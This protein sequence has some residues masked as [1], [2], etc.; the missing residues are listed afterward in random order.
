MSEP[1]YGLVYP[2][3]VCQSQGGPYDDGAFVAGC[4][5]GVVREKCERGDPVIEG[6]EPVALVPQLD[7]L[8][9]A[10]G[11]D[12]VSEPWEDDPDGYWSLVTLTKKDQP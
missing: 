8:A 7:L 5:F 10:K 12:L 9:M 2:F 3:V 4:R 11:Y 1:E 6:Y